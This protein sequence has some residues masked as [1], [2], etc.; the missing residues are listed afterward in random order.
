MSKKINIYIDNKTKK[1]LDDI[2]YKYHLSYS[3]IINII[4]EKYYMVIPAILEEKYIYDKQG[5]KTSIKPRKQEYKKPSLVMTNALMI[6]INKD[7]E[8]FLQD[9]RLREKVN[10]FIYDDLQNTYEDNWD[11]N[12][13]NRIMPKLLKN[14]RDYYKRILEN[15]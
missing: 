13:F 8:K 15:E 4:T 7:L 5:N 3:T 12:R 9:K 6:F 14:N 11:G 1:R 2:K 10:N